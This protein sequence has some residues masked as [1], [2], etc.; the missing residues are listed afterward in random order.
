M[1][2]ENRWYMNLLPFFSYFIWHKY[3]EWVVKKFRVQ[4][5]IFLKLYIII[6]L[7]MDT[8]SLLWSVDTLGDWFFTIFVVGLLVT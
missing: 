1:K 6:L 5:L 2:Y 4:I 7:H 8:D 3:G